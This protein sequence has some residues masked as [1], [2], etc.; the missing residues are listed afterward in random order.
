MTIVI[1]DRYSAS[2][3]PPPDSKTMCKG[4]CEGIGFYPTNDKK[5]WPKNA[6]PDAA[7]YVFVRCQACNG[8]GRRD[9]K[10]TVADI[11]GDVRKIKKAIRG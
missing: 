4:Q 7:G 2:G 11:G 3:R 6:K 5:E 1:S 8:T 9:K 10:G